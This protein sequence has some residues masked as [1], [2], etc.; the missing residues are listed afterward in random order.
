MEANHAWIRKVHSFFTVS[1]MKSIQW[2]V[3]AA[4]AFA[5]A[6]V[7]CSQS[8]DTSPVE[9]TPEQIQAAKEWQ[10]VV[11]KEE[12]QQEKLGLRGTA[13]DPNFLIVRDEE[14]EHRREMETA[15]KAKREKEAA[16]KA[17]RRP[18][19]K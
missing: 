14:L 6:A 16:E 12:K 9:P 1:E 2:V 7:G 3:M 4:V 5:T 8:G 19:K 17:K 15:E 13:Y 18:L 10:A 11:D